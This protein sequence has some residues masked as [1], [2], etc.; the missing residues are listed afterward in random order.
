MALACLTHI[1][2]NDNL[3]IYCHCNPVTNYTDLLTAPLSER[4]VDDPLR[5][6]DSIDRTMNLIRPEI[7]IHWSVMVK[8]LNLAH[9]L[10][11]SIHTHRGPNTYAIVH[12]FLKEAELETKDEIPI[13]LLCV[14]IPCVTV[15]CS[16][17]DTTV[18]YLISFLVTDPLRK[19]C[20]VEKDLETELLLFI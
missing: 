6:N 11:S 5:R 20:S 9:A 15:A 16:H 19:I 2:V 3:T 12:A 18:K 1:C 17:V 13:L 7:S 4:F 14:K 8:N 10:I